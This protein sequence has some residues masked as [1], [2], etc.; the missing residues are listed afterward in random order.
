MPI[1][2]YLNLPLSHASGCHLAFAIQPECNCKVVVAVSSLQEAVN[3]DFVRSLVIYMTRGISSIGFNQIEQQSYQELRLDH[4]V[5]VCKAHIL[6]K[7]LVVFK[8]VKGGE[9]TYLTKYCPTAVRL[10]KTLIFSV[11]ITLSACPAAQVPAD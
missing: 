3:G 1:A 8:Q 9:S 11:V 5:Y 4:A 2:R 7:G 10:A 6:T